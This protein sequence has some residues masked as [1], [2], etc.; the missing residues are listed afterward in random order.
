MTP[1]ERY[2]PD[3]V[4]GQ[5]RRRIARGSGTSVGEVNEL[6][7]QFKQMRKMFK[8][9]GKQGGFMQKIAGRRMRKAKKKKWQELKGQKKKP[10]DMTR[11]LRGE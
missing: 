9:A 10:F 6:L 2:H 4:D 3:L 1:R 5:R 8:D 7:K 11:Y